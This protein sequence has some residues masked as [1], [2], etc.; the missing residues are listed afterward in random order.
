MA[1][2]AKRHG[3]MRLWRAP[4]ARARGLTAPRRAAGCGGTRLRRAPPGSRARPRRLAAPYQPDASRPS[5]CTD[6]TLL[7]PF[8]VPTGRGSSLSLYQP[9]ASRP[10]PRTNR[11]RL[12]PFPVPT[13]RAHRLATSI[14]RPAPVPAAA[15]P[16]GGTRPGRRFQ[17]LKR[18][19]PVPAQNGGGATADESPGAVGGAGRAAPPPPPSY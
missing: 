8:P 15:A 7:V 16:R 14:R 13:G 5:P 4:A 6:R 1:P 3:V 9:D 18:F 12:V 17:R 19:V 10:F 2:R 11:T